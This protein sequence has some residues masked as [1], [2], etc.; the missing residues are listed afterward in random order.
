MYIFEYH[1]AGLKNNI[2]ISLSHLCPCGL[3]NFP[4]TVNY[5]SGKKLSHCV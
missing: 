2:K 4:F 5:L 3:H 1:D